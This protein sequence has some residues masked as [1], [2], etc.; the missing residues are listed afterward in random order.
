VIKD[1]DEQ[2]EKQQFPTEVTL[3]G[4]VIKNTMNNLK[5]RNFQLK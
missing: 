2:P 4:I 3:F 1:K 5:N